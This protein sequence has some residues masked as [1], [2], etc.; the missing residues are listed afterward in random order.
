MNKSRGG[1]SFLGALGVLFIGLKLTGNI[2]WPWV[3]VLFPIL[4]PFIVVIL[5]IVFVSIAACLKDR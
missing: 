2:D 3:V 1:I 5:I 4:W